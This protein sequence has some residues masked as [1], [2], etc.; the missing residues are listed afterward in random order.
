MLK[1][2]ALYIVIV[3]ALVIGLLCSS[4]IVAA[5]FYKIQYQQ[6]FRYDKLANNLGSGIHILLAGT[7]TAYNK[8]KTFSL[9]GGDAD[10]V[11]LKKIT[12][13]LYDI[14]VVKVFIQKDT[15]YKTFSI[16]NTID[17]T[18]WAAFYII[19]ENKPLS[20][21]GKT[22]LQGDIYVPK[23]KINTAYI[24]GKS[25]T[26]DDRLIIGN[27]HVSKKMLPVLQQKKLLEL[28][29]ILNQ[30]HIAD[31]SINNDSVRV[32]FLSPTR[33][34]NFGKKVTILKNIQ[35]IGNIILFSDTSMFIDSSAV[36]NNVMVFAKSIIIKNGFHGNC[37]LFATDSISAESN[38]IFNYP[39]CLGILSFK[40]ISVANLQARIHLGENSKL[41]GLIFTYKKNEDEH[42]P[43]IKLDKDVKITGQ[44]YSQGM[45]VTGDG[46]EVS[47]SVYTRSYYYQSSVTLFENY[48][49]NI[50]ID[51]KALSPYYLTST[52]M[53]VAG[54]KKKILKWLEAN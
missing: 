32:S 48:M 8:A 31:T 37:Q 16:A 53:P 22:F 36:L 21:S 24:D 14:G 7:D 45:L 17:S 3:I 38:C 40:Q 49:V 35:L 9:F 52:I 44:I 4:L 2:S 23:G 5:Y 27:A 50:S 47:G 43:L 18:K 13:G 26:G 10:S 1:A 42:Q 29:N 6:K 39:S 15:L 25:Y 54:K 46:D 30:T 34:V 20:L 12:W 11:S 51:S 28:E 41:S 33:T 19:D